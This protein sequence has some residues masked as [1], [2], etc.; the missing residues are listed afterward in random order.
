[1]PVEIRRSEDIVALGNKMRQLTGDDG[2]IAS[3][4]GLPVPELLSHLNNDYGN[5]CRLIAVHGQDLR[6]CHAF[7]KW[8]VWDGKRWAVDETEQARRLAKET[9]IELLRQAIYSR[10]G[11]NMEKFASASL[12]SRRIASML[13]MA[14]PEI[15]VRPSDLDTDPYLLNFS[16]GTVDLRSGVLKRHERRDFITKLIPLPFVPT[17]KCPQWFMFLTKIMGGGAD[18]PEKQSERAGRLIDYLQT[19]F[20]YSLTGCTIEKAVFVLFGSGNNGKS[21]LLSTFRQ[22][23]EEYSMLLQVDTLMVR[24]ESNNT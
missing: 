21:T 18:V 10:A 7:K 9:M 17:A 16:N 11:E 3:S 2:A 14:Q 24:Q 13:S 12:D 22:L 23:V 8:L 19:A 6:F 20:G 15:Y 4:A 1:M 5:A